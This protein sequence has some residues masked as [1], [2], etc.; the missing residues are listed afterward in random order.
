MIKRAAFSYICV[1]IRL[2][3][4]DCRRV[5]TDDKCLGKGSAASAGLHGL[6][7]LS[8]GAVVEEDVEFHASADPGEGQ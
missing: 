5:Y 3:C 6:S 1:V 8:N 7:L 4:V 2:M